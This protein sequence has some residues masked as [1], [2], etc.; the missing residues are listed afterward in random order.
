MSSSR[1]YSKRDCRDVSPLVVEERSYSNKSTTS[2]LRMERSEKQF[3]LTM[4]KALL[5]WKAELQEKHEREMDYLQGKHQRELSKLKTIMME[6]M[7]ADKERAMQESRQKDQTE[8]ESLK[9]QV[10]M[11]KKGW[12]KERQEWQSKKQSLEKDLDPNIWSI[13]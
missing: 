6:T 7:E 5:D 3:H 10:I 4:H 8:I 2:S 1:Y 13:F 9:E 12:K 11:L